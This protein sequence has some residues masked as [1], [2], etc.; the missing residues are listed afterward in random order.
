MKN[1]TTFTETT[2][3]LAGYLDKGVAPQVLCA[4][5]PYADKCQHFTLYW[6]CAV[7]QET[8]GADQ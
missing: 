5:C 3:K 4:Q 1:Q 6:H 8:E 2:R 7:W